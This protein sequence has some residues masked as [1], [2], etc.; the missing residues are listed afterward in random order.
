MLL[1]LDGRA[2][3]EV[4]V[5]IESSIGSHPVRIALECR[6]HV[7]RQGVTWIEH[8][9]GKYRHLPVDQVVAVSRS[10]FTGSAQARA[11]RV[12]IRLLTLDEA[13]ALDWPEKFTRWR[14][15]LVLLRYRLRTAGPV[16]KSD[17]GQEMS[18]EE[19][20]KCAISDG[21]SKPNSTFENDVVR[22]YKQDGEAAVQSWF[23]ENAKVVWK[24]GPGK[25]WDII[26]SY[27]AHDRYLHAPDGGV[28]QLKEIVIVL[29]AHYDL[30]S[31][32][33]RNYRYYTYNGAR[34]FT[35]E[36]D[37]AESKCIYQLV[38]LSDDEGSPKS[39]YVR[40]EHKDISCSN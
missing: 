7:R 1:E 35:G 9:E 4:D 11:A 21:S 5:L 26:I 6:D 39:W 22:I 33:A 30:R 2:E 20:K 8:L 24:G 23:R 19:T 18:G 40:T 29:R 13:M 31:V 25:D 17:A 15:G 28:I 32:D 37:D 34:L 12:N 10:G 38:T 16:Y 14:M 3:R 36:V 27:T